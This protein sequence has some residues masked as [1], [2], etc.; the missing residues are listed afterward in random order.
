MLADC[1]YC[2]IS[3]QLPK[4]VPVGPTYA[5]LSVIAEQGLCRKGNSLIIRFF[6]PK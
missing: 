6:D 1:K 3:S 5:H 4:M 2:F